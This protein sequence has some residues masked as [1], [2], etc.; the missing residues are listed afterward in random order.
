MNQEFSFGHVKFEF[1][2][3]YLNGDN[4]SIKVD[5]GGSRS[6]LNR[7]IKPKILF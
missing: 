3:R 4:D 2:I 7:E 6:E 5:I 1:P